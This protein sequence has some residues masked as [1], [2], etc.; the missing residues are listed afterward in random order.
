MTELLLQRT[1][2]PKAVIASE[3]KQSSAE[4]GLWIASS[5]APLAMTATTGTQPALQTRISGLKLGHHD[6]PYPPYRI[7][8]LPEPLTAPPSGGWKT[9]VLMAMRPEAFP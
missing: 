6:D 5:L 8:L 7:G 9:N 2:A 1:L 3:A 4:Q